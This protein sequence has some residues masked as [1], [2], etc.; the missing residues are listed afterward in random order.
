MGM[1]KIGDP[2]GVGQQLK[3]KQCI[4]HVLLKIVDREIRIC[5]VYKADRTY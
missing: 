5:L 4:M 1:Q 2:C 3:H